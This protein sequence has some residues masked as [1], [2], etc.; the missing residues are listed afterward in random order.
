MKRNGNLV[1]QAHIGFAALGLPRT[2]GNRTNLLLHVFEE[3]LNI[4]QVIAMSLKYSACYREHH[5]RQFVA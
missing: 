4:K 1:Y 5:C 3:I 2:E